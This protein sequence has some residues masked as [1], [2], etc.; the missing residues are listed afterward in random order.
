[1]DS[2]CRVYMYFISE[3]TSIWESLED[4]ILFFQEIYEFI[5]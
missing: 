2:V 4:S 1:M 5:S 3:N